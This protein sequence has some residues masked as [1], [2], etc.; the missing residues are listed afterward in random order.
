MR[1]PDKLTESDLKDAP[2]AADVLV[3]EKSSPKNLPAELD[4]DRQSGAISDRSLVPPVAW[5]ARDFP[6]DAGQAREVRRW[7]ED[8]LPECDVLADVLLVASELCA[9]AI[10]HTRSGRAGGRFSV[11]VEWAWELARVVV[12]DR[13][14][15]MVP[16]AG[17]GMGNATEESGRGL[18]LVDQ[19]AD[20]WGTA[21]HP[22]GRVVWVDV[23]WHARGGLPLEVPGNADAS[24]ADA[25]AM[26]GL[27]P[28]ATVWWGHQTRAWWAAL[29]GITGAGGL[30]TSPTA[31]GLARA[32]AEACGHLGRDRG[33]ASWPC[34]PAV[35]VPVLGGPGRGNP[36]IVPLS[37]PENAQGR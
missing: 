1:V 35:G 37:Q 36:V 4:K 13:G 27:F 11:S 22:A 7:I 21:G 32:V 14:S 5:W 12:G 6:G 20:A 28:G 15:A 30:V 24:L 26:R 29:P 18:R 31:R 2:E 3:A 34:D 33:D 23:D 19:L 25:A 16:L 10:T 8:L 17:V 9:N